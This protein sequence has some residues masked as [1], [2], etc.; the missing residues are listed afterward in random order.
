MQPK[1]LHN[2]GWAIHWLMPQ[3]K[4]PIETG[5]TTGPRK[6]WAQLKTQYKKGYNVGVRLGTPS[7][8][9]DGYLSVIDVDVKSDNPKHK[10]E[11]YAAIHRLTG[12][13]D[14]TYPRVWSGRGNGS[15]HI[16]GRTKVAATPRRI[17]QSSETVKVRMPSVEKTSRREIEELTKSEIR[18]GIRLRPAWE[19]SLM[20]T[21]QQVVLPP[22]I[23]PDS[24]KAYKWD[25]EW[26]EIPELKLKGIKFDSNKDG[27]TDDVIED[28]K[29]KKIDILDLGLSDDLTDLILSGKGCEDR[30]AA[31]FS[32]SMQMARAGCD[33]PTI[34]SV[35]T[36]SST[37]LGQ[38]AFDHAQ[39]KSRMRAA[40]WLQK[41]TLKKARYETS[42]AK[43]FAN[44]VDI[45][46]LDDKAA[47]RQKKEL[48]ESVDW[49][50]KIERQTENGPPKPTIKNIVLILENLK[51]EAIFI[52][53]EFSNRTSYGVNAPWGGKQG[54]E[55]TDEDVI[56]IRLWLA[57]KYRFEPAR[58]K[59]S[60]S[61]THLAHKNAFHPV[62]D[63]L[64]GLKW[65]GRERINTWLKDYSGAMGPE[66]YL[67][68]V[69]RKVLI[70]MVARIFRPGIKFDHVL[71]LEGTQGIGKSSIPRI[72]AGENW[73]NETL[74][75]IRDKDAMLNLLGAWV[76]EISE[77]ATLRK[78]DTESYKAF[79]TRQADRVRAPYGERW[80]EY[81]RQCV[82]IG[83]TNSHDYLSDKTGNRRFWPVKIKQLDFKGLIDIRDQLFA[84]AVWHW[85]NLSEE[86]YLSGETNKQAQR[87]QASR[88]AEDEEDA[89]AHQ[90]K[91]WMND[92]EVIDLDRFKLSDLFG[93]NGPWPN[94]R[95]DGW[96]MR[97]SSGALRI[98]GFKNYRTGKGGVW[99]KQGV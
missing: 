44:L 32:V 61:I 64:S 3:S 34:L 74:P 59:V 50:T 41:Y 29:L 90:I 20:G 88:V 2:L 62:R 24:G 4:R 98:L 83:T 18:D 58:D 16:Y 15:C 78:T 45:K 75:D 54:Q 37:Y 89:M 52:H 31:L 92:Q 14:K 63:Y 73:Y 69:S 93:E 7:K 28:I 49:K 36:D 8:V 66:P 17:T 87:V 30:S 97:K 70:A 79:F 84:E 76:N 9:N 96:A 11:A 6:S 86:L 95:A 99:W 60:D 57:K 42:A 94:R 12:N 72:L 85:K 1:E 81:K 22:S 53:N 10:A 82:F 43:D 68:E 51:P 80:Q 47:Q 35:L 67:S 21:G 65:D 71:V 27:G 25:G 40:K 56:N 39:T 13:R 91:Q 46:P 38:A 23:H 48:V 19:I 33:N 5:W 55:I 77:L 26:F